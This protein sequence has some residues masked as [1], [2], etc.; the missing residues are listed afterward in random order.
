MIL[1]TLLL[2]DSMIGK[3]ITVHTKR[4]PGFQKKNQHAPKQ[5]TKSELLH[6]FTAVKLL[7]F[8]F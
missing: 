8:I 1:D 3:E 5:E 6:L 7:L 4:E 2:L